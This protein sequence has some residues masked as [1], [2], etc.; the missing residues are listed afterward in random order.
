[1]FEIVALTTWLFYPLQDKNRIRTDALD[2]SLSI[3]TN[4][5]MSKNYL[6]CLLYIF[7]C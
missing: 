4:L 1:M 2:V 6:L 7:V 3:T 5:C